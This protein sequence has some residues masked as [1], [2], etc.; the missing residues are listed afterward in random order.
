MATLNDAILGPAGGYDQGRS[1]RS[2]EQ[3]VACPRVCGA[4]IADVCA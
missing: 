1:D 2:I 4:T 3:I